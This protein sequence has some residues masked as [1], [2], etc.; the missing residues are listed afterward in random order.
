M[1][2]PRTPTKGKRRSIPP[3]ENVELEFTQRFLTLFT[4]FFDTPSTEEILTFPP[5]PENAVSDLDSQTPQKI[6]PFHSGVWDLRLKKA[7]EA[8]QTNDQLTSDSLSEQVLQLRDSIAAESPDLQEIFVPEKA[9]RPEI[10]LYLQNIEKDRQ[11]LLATFK[12]PKKKPLS[13]GI[14][15]FEKLFTERLRR[16]KAIQKE[17]RKRRFIRAREIEREHKA[18]VKTLPATKFHEELDKE[19]TRK[20]KQRKADMAARLKAANSPVKSPRAQK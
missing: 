18:F 14:A 15:E 7:V 5:A 3:C 9:E 12:P 11:A 20:I 17:R 6:P 8:R 2:S 19:E 10:P 4:S 13:L 16:Q 1:T